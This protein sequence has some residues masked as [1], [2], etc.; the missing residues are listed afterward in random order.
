VSVIV[1]DALRAL[2][3]RS[4]L[5]ELEMVAAALRKSTDPEVLALFGWSAP[6]WECEA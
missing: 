1:L 3:P 4:A 5:C 6:I 2:G